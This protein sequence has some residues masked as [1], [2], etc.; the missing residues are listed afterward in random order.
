MARRH[1]H[2]RAVHAAKKAVVHKSRAKKAKDQHVGHK[3]A[4]QVRTVNAP[5]PW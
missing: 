5:R 3:G 1:V 4:G 2:R